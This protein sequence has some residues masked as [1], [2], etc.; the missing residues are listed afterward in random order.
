M[1]GCCL[2]MPTT[3]P[4]QYQQHKRHG[5]W[6]RLVGNQLDW[7]INATGK[8]LKTGPRKCGPAFMS[9]LGEQTWRANSV[10][11]SLRTMTY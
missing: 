5:C 1:E 10:S 9:R 2:A 6:A 11:Q 3:E 8:R 4:E 7:A